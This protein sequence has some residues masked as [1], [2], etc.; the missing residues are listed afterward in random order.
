MLSVKDGKLYLQYEIYQS[1]S[2]YQWKALILHG[3]S[4]IKEFLVDHIFS[5]KNKQILVNKIHHI[6]LVTC[7]V[8]F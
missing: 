7:T 5:T 6:I 2:A 3:L 1:I 8:V 4:G